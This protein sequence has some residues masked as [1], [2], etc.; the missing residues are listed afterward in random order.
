MTGAIVTHEYFVDW[1][2]EQGIDAWDESIARKWEPMS[3]TSQDVTA[4]AEAFIAKQ[5]GKKWFLWCHYL[6]PHGRY[7]AH[8][9]DVQFG[10]T[11]EDLYDGEI[12]YTDKYLGRL[13]DYVSH[14]PAAAKT[15]ILITSDHGDAFNEH[16]FINHANALYRELLQ[17]PLLVYVPDAEP[18]TVDGPVSG[19]DL[20]PTI[21]DLAGADI[22]GL[23]V[24]GVSLVPQLFYGRDA[25]ERVVFAETNLPDVQR[26]A[27]SNRW[28]LIYHIKSNVSELYDLAKDPMEKKN[29]FAT[30]KVDAER[31]KALID[32]WLDRVYYA[33]DPRS[34]AERVREEQ[35]LLRTPPKPEHPSDA[36]VGGVKIVGW[37]VGPGPFA[38]GKD[39]SVTVYLTIA[40]PMQMNYRV[41]AELF[42]TPASGPRLSAK[43]ERTPAGDGI[44]PTSKWR[45]G[46][47]VKETF[48][49]R[50]PPQSP[51]ALTLG[52]RLLDAARKPAALPNGETQLVL[53]TLPVTPP[54]P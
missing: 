27:I 51:E 17:V 13:I 24:E 48:K 8:P 10:T 43:Q 7:V 3:I 22:S 11:E 46:E 32:E 52:I 39:V 23:N 33:R 9:G 25:K 1:G 54:G 42:A 53:G 20:F 31:M 4:K 5:G 12:A 49:L 18:H 47:F 16:G 38:P 35:F 29:V 30:E 50:I 41:E 19:L 21:A 44:F 37:D 36:E 40:A 2:L 15:V 34:Q 14:S 26:A 45:P 6:D 28:K